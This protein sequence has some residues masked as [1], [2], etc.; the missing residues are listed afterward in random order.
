MVF[1]FNKNK[2]ISVRHVNR[3][4][5]GMVVVDLLLTFVDSNSITE[6]YAAMLKR[7]P[8]DARDEINHA[9]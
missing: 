4:E 6:M 7:T 9:I 1:S 5:T 2:K 8:P 3:K